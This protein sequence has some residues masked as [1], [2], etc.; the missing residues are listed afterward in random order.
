MY[1]LVTQNLIDAIADAE[2]W[3]KGQGS[4]YTDTLG[5]CMKSDKDV[6]FEENT[7]NRRIGLPS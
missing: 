4:Y 2:Q 3:E 6:C 7:W 5:V 1:N